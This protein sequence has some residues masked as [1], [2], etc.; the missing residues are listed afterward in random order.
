VVPLAEQVARGETG[1]AAAEDER[2]LRDVFHHWGRRQLALI[3]LEH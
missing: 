3:R 1:G 2:R